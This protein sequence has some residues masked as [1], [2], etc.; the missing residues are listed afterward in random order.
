MFTTLVFFLIAVLLMLGVIADSLGASS[1]AEASDRAAWLERP[2][3]PMTAITVADAGILEKRASSFSPFA[4]AAPAAW[5][6]S[7]PCSWPR[8]GRTGICLLQC[9]SLFMAQRVG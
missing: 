3:A 2:S 1:D 6:V 7:P 9:M 5:R 8:R 4:A